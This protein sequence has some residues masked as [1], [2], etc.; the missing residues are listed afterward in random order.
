M[1]EKTYTL[2]EAAALQERKY[3]D[4]ER[5]LGEALDRL[6]GQMSRGWISLMGNDWD[7]LE[8]PSLEQL[9]KASERNRESVALNVHASSGLRA[10]QS[11]VWDGDIH[12]SGIP[13]SGRG[14][15]ANVQARIDN[16]VN[17]LNFFGAEAKDRYQSCMYT[18]GIAFF[19]G[20]ESD[21]TISPIPIGQ[22]T[23]DIRNP[24]LSDE[25]WA[26]RRTWNVYQPGTADIAETKSEWVYANA[27][28]DKRVNT[29][30]Y[31]GVNEPVSRNR[32]FVARTGRMSGWAYGIGEVQAALPW[33]EEYRDLVFKGIDMTDSMS[34]IWASVKSNSQAGADNMAVTIGGEGRSGGVA[35]IGVGQEISVLSSAGAAYDFSKLIPVL[36]NFAAGIGVSVI[37]VSSNPGNA[38]GSYGAAKSL[39]RPEQLS[40]QKRRKLVVDLHRE[41]L[42]WMGAKPED[43]DVWF[44]PITDL[45]EQYRAEQRIELR[46]GTGLYEGEEIKKMHAELDGRDPDKVTKVPEGWLIPNNRESVELRQID[47]NVNISGQAGGDPSNGGGMTPTQGSGA[48]S[49][50]TGSG[51]QNADDI[52]VEAYGKLARD[53]EVEEMRDM[54]VAILA[55]LDG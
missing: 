52:R 42:V 9:R 8:G 44:T 3:A 22:I 15:G 23:D 45:A 39:D 7:Q 19:M 33:A 21:F 2:A 38:G 50:K 20:N 46:L 37:A 27:F 51:D 53:V 31:K 18:D 11:Y 4:M 13:G 17:Q 10:I 43:L 32:M 48:K 41:V 34:R 40:T 1:A 55:K 12:Y 36:S 54:L 16:A 14:R 25:V 28:Y 47:P 24:E 26:W 35:G 6:N 29:V 30:N 49:V 5:M